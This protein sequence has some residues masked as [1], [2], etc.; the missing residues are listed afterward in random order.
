MLELK[1]GPAATVLACLDTE[2]GLDPGG[3]R[4]HIL[5][6]ADF[7]CRRCYAVLRTRRGMEL[8]ALMEAWEAETIGA[9]H[10]YYQGRQQDLKLLAGQICRA[11][12]DENCPGC[13]APMRCPVCCAAR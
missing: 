8:H 4:V 2:P 11:S 13:G 12:H 3:A 5:Q 10:R 7:Q 6:G 9:G 1:P